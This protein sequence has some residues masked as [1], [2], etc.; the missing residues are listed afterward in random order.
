MDPLSRR[1][2]RER[3]GV[4]ESHKIGLE[5]REG[6]LPSVEEVREVDKEISKETESDRWKT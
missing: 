5:N 4:R 3:Q 6:I 2:D 1:N